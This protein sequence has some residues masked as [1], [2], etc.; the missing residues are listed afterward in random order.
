MNNNELFRKIP[1]QKN[2][3]MK[4]QF[5]IFLIIISFGLF[6]SSCTKEKYHYLNES[7]KSFLGR[8]VG[9]S[10]KVVS[11]WPV[12]T[13][14]FVIRSESSDFV[15]VKTTGQVDYLETIRRYNSTGYIQIQKSNTDGLSIEISAYAETFTKIVESDISVEIGDVIYDD[16]YVFHEKIFYL[17]YSLEYGF[18]RY[19]SFDDPQFVFIP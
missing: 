9:D 10:M 18:L 5:I 8:S 6:V 2:L 19:D 14:D 1:S 12:D 13:N 7:D 3:I 17:Y 4:N 15:K 11:A 16:V